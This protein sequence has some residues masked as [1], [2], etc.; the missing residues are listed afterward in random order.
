M[1]DTALSLHVD[2]AQVLFALAG[3]LT[4]MQSFLKFWKQRKEKGKRNHDSSS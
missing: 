4:A 2:V 1:I 3:L